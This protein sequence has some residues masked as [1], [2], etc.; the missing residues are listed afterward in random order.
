M[1]LSA[2]L[3]GCVTGMILHSL[4]PWAPAIANII[5]MAFKGVN[6]IASRKMSVAFMLP[7]SMRLMFDWT[8]LFHCIDQARDFMLIN[9]NPQ[10]SDPFY[11]L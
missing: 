7:L 10:N 9:Y 6:M 3:S 1:F 8:P 5:S 2:W 4:K 11:H